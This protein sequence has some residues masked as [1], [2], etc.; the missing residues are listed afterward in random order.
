MKYQDIIYYEDE[1]N[2]DF[3]T[4]VKNI[5]PLPDNYKFISNNFLVKIFEFIGYRML[6]TPFAFIYCKIKFNYKIKNKKILK[7]IKNGYFIYGNHTTVLGDAFLPNLVS[8]KTKNHIITGKQANSLTFILPILRAVGALPLSENINH[9]KKL[10]K[11]INKL[12]S[13]NKSITIFPEAHVWPYY[14]DIRPFTSDSFKYAVRLN[15]AVVSMTTCFQKRKFFKTPKIII[16]LD[17]PYYPDENL[18]INENAQLL[19][20]KV[21]D[22]MK[23]NCKKYSTYSYFTYINKNQNKI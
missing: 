22:S 16:Y 4:T 19:R 23:E 13:K 15:A 3:A 7:Q 9:K 11:S 5:K 10:L 20:N 8:F 12:I 14:T 1:L 17:G 18:T 21:Y 2:D 6:M